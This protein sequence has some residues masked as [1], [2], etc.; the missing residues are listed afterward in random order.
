MTVSYKDAPT[1]TVEVDGFP[2]AYRQV[3]TNGGVRSYCCT[4]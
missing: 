3:G 4:T 2:F 1:T